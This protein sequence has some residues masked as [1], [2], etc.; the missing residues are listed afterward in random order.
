MMFGSNQPPVSSRP[1]APGAAYA[2]FVLVLVGALLLA[3]VAGRCGSTGT[4]VLVLARQAASC[5]RCQHWLR[6]DE[7]WLAGLP[8][9]TLS[10][11]TAGPGVPVN[12]DSLLA[13][14]RRLAEL[15]EPHRIT[16]SG[17]KAV[18]PVSS[19]LRDRWL[20]RGYLQA[21]VEMVAGSARDPDT[22]V[23][24]PGVEWTLAALQVD[25]DDF[26]GRQSLLSDRLPSAGERFSPAR[27]SEALNGILGALGERGYPFPRWVTRRID[28]DPVRHTVAVTGTLLPGKLTVIGP[29]TS[30]LPPGPGRD[31]LARASG[32]R[33]GVPLTSS[34]LTLAVQRLRARDLYARVDEPRVYLT[35][36]ADTV[37]VHFP[38]VPRRKVNRL[39]VVLGLSRGNTTGPSRLSGQVDLDLPNMA[40]TGRGL[41]AGW[42]DDGSGTSSFGVEYREPLVLGTPLDMDL[43]MASEVHQGTYTRF[44]MNSGWELPVVA[45]WGVGLQVGWDRAT[46]PA[47][48]LEKSTRLRAGGSVLHKRG[49]RYR[50]G[51]SGSFGITSAWGST[52]VRDA[53]EDS[54]GSGRLGQS[55]SVRIYNVDL[56]GEIRLGPSLGLAG[57]A[58]FRQQAGGQRIVP[59]AEQFWIGGA[60]TV[61]GYNEREFHGSKVAWGGVELRVG[62]VRSSRLYTFWDLGYFEFATG[63]PADP[64]LVK[65]V[66]G[67]PRG[68]GLGLLAR[69]RGGD[70]SL[71]VGFP[72]SVDFDLAK[73]H[74]TLLEAF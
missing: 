66:S 27:V 3:P 23:I 59:L 28:L 68:Y 70:L 62:R 29:I 25:G 8:Q 26:P 37:G 51:W 67:H 72:G 53:G 16:A 12:L 17:A 69:T 61:R 19:L 9:P 39:A 2:R 54:L 31:F 6:E 7:A 24:T 36:A 33:R 73:L 15:V 34:A 30:D 55:T 35:Q 56:Q 22:L 65:T 13:H 5:P 18:R 21:V 63:D 74:V 32:L 40:G 38:V 71:A 10:L 20:D 57:R 41:R 52:R 50:S 14:P 44:D 60:N 58:S 47:G 46:Y 49:D 11:T 4:P 64:T 45:L 43:G 42:R 48:E 1:P